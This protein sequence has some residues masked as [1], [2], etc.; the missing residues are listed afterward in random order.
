MKSPVLFGI[1]LALI[2]SCGDVPPSTVEAVRGPLHFGPAPAAGLAPL[3]AGADLKSAFSA[4]FAPDD[5]T[6]TLELGL[7]DAVISARQAD[8]RSYD[9]SVNPYRI[10]YSV[11]NISYAPIY[12]RLA[13]A[14]EKG[15]AVQIQIDAR[16]IDPTAARETY[17]VSKGFKVVVDNRTLTDA[18]RASANLIGIQMM[19]GLMHTKMRIYETPAEKWLLSGSQNPSSEAQLNE[20]TL[21]LVRDLPII[22][23]YAAAYEAIQ[24]GQ[25][26]TNSWTPGAALNV[27]FAPAASAPFPGRQILD[28]IAA[29]NEQILLMMF[30]LNDFTAPGGGKGLIDLLKAKAAAGVPVWVLTDRK[31]ADGVDASGKVIGPNNPTDEELTAAG[32]QVYKVLNT[33]GAY[34]AMHSKAAILGRTQLRVI[35]DT[36][37]YSLSALGSATTL[38]R[39]YESVMFIDSTALDGGVTGRRYLAQWLKVL[40][41]W[42]DQSAAEGLPSYTEALRQLSAATGWPGVP[43]TFTALRTSTGFGEEVRVLGELKPL[44][45]WSAAYTGVMLHTEAAY[46]PTWHSLTAVDLPLGSWFEW[47]LAVGWGTGPATRWESGANRSDFVQTPPLSPSDALSYEVAWK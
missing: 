34:T 9:D 35:T 28:W 47:K 19:S 13:E 37:N 25:R 17:L 2:A 12:E 6:L 14:K 33:A 27:L 3:P 23:A 46:Y 18:T 15:V 30:S 38:P 10:R 43:T 8:A 41:R 45:A 26:V 22:A 20:E 7:I 32:V 31:Q 44:G 42:A 11:Q 4:L 39:N 5:P 40:S 29:E 36:A 16:F 21:H 1:F 24:R